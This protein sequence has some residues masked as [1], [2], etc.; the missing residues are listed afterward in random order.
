MFKFEITPRVF[1]QDALVRVLSH[2]AKRLYQRDSVKYKPQLLEIFSSLDKISDES[3]SGIVSVLKATEYGLF[4]QAVLE[5]GFAECLHGVRKILR[6]LCEDLRKNIF[7]LCDDVSEDLAY[8]LN[9]GRF[10]L[11]FPLPM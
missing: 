9:H 10:A 7:M 4:D 2:L 8:L 3:L 1:P 5:D 6:V 11:P